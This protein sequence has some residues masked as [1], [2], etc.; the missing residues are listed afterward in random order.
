MAAL[1]TALSWGLGLSLGGMVGTLVYMAA[2]EWL[3]RVLGIRETVESIAEFNRRAHAESLDVF[4]TRNNLT[5]DII[6]ALSRI[7]EEI[8]KHRQMEKNQR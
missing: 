5:E 3:R 2:A 4:R 8:E 1:L 7:A 6:V